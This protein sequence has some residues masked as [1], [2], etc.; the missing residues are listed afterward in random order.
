MRVGI[1]FAAAELPAA[2]DER[3][4]QGSHRIYRLDSYAVRA[5][6]RRLRRRTLA[7]E[8]DGVLRMP[9]CYFEVSMHPTKTWMLSSIDTS[10]DIVDRA[11]KRNLGVLASPGDH[12]LLRFGTA[13]VTLPLY[14]ICGVFGDLTYVMISRTP[15]EG[16]VNI[17]PP[18][19]P[20]D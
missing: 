1:M 14:A 9:N 10:S 7:V 3:D 17:R 5:S 16:W 8:R 20:G 19:G 15:D 2:T 13:F 12:T 11:I 6:T 18:S 4:I